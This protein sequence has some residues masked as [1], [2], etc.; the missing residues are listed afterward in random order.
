MVIKTSENTHTHKH[1]LH[2][3]AIFPGEPG[4]ASCL[5]NSPS[6]F[7]PRLCI[8]LGQAW[9][10][11]IIQNIITPGVFWASSLSNSFNFPFYKTFMTQSISSFRS[12]HPNHLNLLFLII[13]LRVLSVLQILHCAL[14]VQCIVICPV[15]LCV[16]VCV[17][18]G[19]L[20]R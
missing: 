3:M 15:C 7:I 5:L 14:A 18:V 8:L 2:L 12:I 13:I 16:W 19:L 4:L 17:F 20:P 6:P 1:T 10:F 9:T 11:H